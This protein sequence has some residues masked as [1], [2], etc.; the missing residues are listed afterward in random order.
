MR[1]NAFYAQDQWTH[2]RL[3]L[4]GALRYD[5]AWSYYP[6]QQIGPTRFLP[7]ALVFPDR[8]GRSATTTSARGGSGLRSLR[9]RE[10]GAQVQ[11]RAGIWKRRSTATETTRRS[12]RPRAC[13]QRDADLERCQPQLRSRL[14]SDERAAQNLLSSGGDSCGQ[15]SNLNFGKN[16]YS[17]SYDQQILKGWGVRPADWQIGVTVQQEILPRMSMEVGYSRRWLQ[18]FTVT[19]NLAAAR[20]TSAVQHHGAARSAAAGRR[21]IHR[22]R[23]VRR[24]PEQVRADQQ[25]S[26]LSHRITATCRR[27]TTAW[28]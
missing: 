3:T 19:D 21:R 9:Q 20:P 13:H 14:R 15:V 5:H 10:D 7:T 2:G 17:L 25:L 8:G 16:V 1:Y 18:N 12:S 6:A 22:L 23:T 26:H 24:R 4:Q 28:S 27:S 11:R